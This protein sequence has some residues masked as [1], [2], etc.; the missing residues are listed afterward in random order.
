[1]KI[2]GRILKQ[3]NNLQIRYSDLYKYTVWTPDGKICLEDRFDSIDEAIEYCKETKDFL[4]KPAK[5]KKKKMSVRA[6]KNCG[7]YENDL[8]KVQKFVDRIDWKPFHEHL[9]QFGFDTEIETSLDTDCGKYRVHVR[10][11]ENLADKTGIMATCFSWVRLMDFGSFL[12]QSVDYDKDL[13]DQAM[14]N[15]EYDK[16][17]TDFDAQFGPITLEVHMH[18]RFEE[19]HGGQNSLSLFYAQ[20]TEESGWEFH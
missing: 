16:T 13:Y 17:W 9:K 14:A 12:Y 20:Y 11:K 8:D 1:M 3:V 7:L 2:K 15:H 10:G 19:K 18:L 4:A 5:P 6:G